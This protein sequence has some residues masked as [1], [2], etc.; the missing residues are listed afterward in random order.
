MCETAFHPSCHDSHRSFSSHDVLNDSV[1][2]AWKAG[3]G[4][5]M[6][7]S[8]MLGFAF[9]LLHMMLTILEPAGLHPLVIESYTALVEVLGLYLQGKRG[10]R[11]PPPVPHRARAVCTVRRAPR[12]RSPVPASAPCR[13][14]PPPRPERASGSA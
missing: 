11:A 5:K 10:A 13:V 3:E 2:N 7:A 6:G 14:C 9:A 1:E 4:F 8:P 12:P